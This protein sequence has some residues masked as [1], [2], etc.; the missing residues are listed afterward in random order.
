[1]RKDEEII[2][3]IKELKSLDFRGHQR[4]DLADYL[5]AEQLEPLGFKVHNFKTLPRDADSIMEQMKAYMIFAWGK[6]NNCRG[7]SA[8]RSL[9][10]YSAWLWMLG[11]TVDFSHYTHYGKP[12]L[13]AICERFG[14]DWQSL[15]NGR[16]TNDGLLDGTPA[17][18]TVPPL[19]TYYA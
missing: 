1:M 15:D 16:W 17:P 3:R 14:W 13:R 7:L 4:S 12:Q 9:D 19:E 8:G 2:A 11:M 18:E 10:H 6:A 5:T